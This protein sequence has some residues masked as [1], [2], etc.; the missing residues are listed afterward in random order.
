MG[1][2]AQMGVLLVASAA[3]SCGNGKAEAEPSTP[4]QVTQPRAFETAP[5]KSAQASALP[6]TALPMEGEPAPRKPPDRLLLLEADARGEPCHP[7]K[8]PVRLNFEDAPIAD[9]I[10]EA[11]RW[12]C[13]NFAFTNE[14][15]KGE[16][17]VLSKTPVSTDEAYVLLAAALHANNIAMYRSGKYYN[18]VRVSDAKKTPIPTLIDDEAGTPATEQ[19]VTRVI[20]LKYA[21][22]DAMKKVVANFLSPAGADIQGIPP[23]LLII[24]D[25]GLNLRRVERLI[26][27]IDQPGRDRRR[28]ADHPEAATAS[29]LPEAERDVR[30]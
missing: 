25:I 6:K 12:S 3:V 27:E 4:R 7:V 29:A 18:L 28:W 10:R 19:P 17:T 22:A 23:D 14:V 11:S 21:D 26:R 2:Y 9:V 20:R 16:I 5:V 13:R 15:A 30:R 1:W 8:G 24:T